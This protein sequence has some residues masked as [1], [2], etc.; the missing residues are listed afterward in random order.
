MYLALLEDE[1]MTVRQVF[2]RL[3]SSGVIG[4]TE[5]EYKS[6]VVRLLG[7]MR[8]NGEIEFNWIADNTRWM[9]KPRT[10]SSLESMLKRTAE[11]YRRSVWDNQECYV[12]IWLEKDALAGVLFEETGAWDVPLMVTRGYPSISFLHGAAEMIAA[13]DKP[14]YL[15]YFGDYDPSGLDIPRKVE[16]DLREFAPDADIEFERVA[17]TRE[18]IS[19][20]KLPTRPTKRTDSRAKGFIGESVEVDAIPPKVLRQIVSQCITQHIDNDAYDVML[21]AEESERTTLMSLIG[22]RSAHYLTFDQN[23]T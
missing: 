6:T 3:V 5:G 12:E 9:R 23:K 17:V 15:Y 2:Y 14:T 18:Q 7:D 8:R 22:N 21:K 10:Y 4:K 19:S 20:M 16:S 13:Q 11:A 1:P